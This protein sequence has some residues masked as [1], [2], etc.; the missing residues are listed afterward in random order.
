MS[1]IQKDFEDFL[2]IQVLT[3]THKVSRACINNYFCNKTNSFIKR[4]ETVSEHIVWCLSLADFY[5]TKYEEFSHLSEL[6]IYNLLRYHDNIEWEKSIWDVS[7][8]D[9]KRRI[10]NE[11]KEIEI[12]PSYAKTYP[13][14]LGGKFIELDNEFREKQTEESI[15]C[16]AIDKLQPIIY[17]T[18]YPEV[19][20]PSKGFDEA[21]IRRR[22]QP[23]FEP[24]PIIMQHFEMLMDYF[25]KNGHFDD[26]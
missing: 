14:V 16:H 15:F 26:K 3:D 6:K 4:K 20:G 5:L 13:D 25:N 24:F 23:S 1:N 8:A 2:K 19:W 9:E 7:I 22:S 21:A 17:C 12:L 18:P 11:Q 10:T